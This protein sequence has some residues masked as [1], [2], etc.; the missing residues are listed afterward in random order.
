MGLGLTLSELELMP[1]AEYR[2]WTMFYEEEPWGDVRADLRSG[3]VAALI[4]KTMG[5]RKNARPI[6][7]MPVVQS[8]RKADA[9]RM[10]Q[11]QKN[12]VM[13]STFETNLGPMRV[14]RVRIKRGN[15]G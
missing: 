2:S 12:R 5:G 1:V 7:F 6:D 10:T 11:R 14:H 9:S 8:Q 13:R 3:I 4:A 15:R